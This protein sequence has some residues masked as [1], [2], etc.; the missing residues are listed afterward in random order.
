[1][2]ATDYALKLD[3]SKADRDLIQKIVERSDTLYAL[4]GLK[5]DRLTRSLDLTAC[6]CNG[7]PLDLAKLLAF[8]DANFGH[9]VLGIRRHIDRHT[10]KLGDCFLPRCAKPVPEKRYPGQDRD[11]ARRERAEER[12]IMRAENGHPDAGYP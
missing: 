3:T 4:V 10:G 2:A 5:D 12:R 1:M 11:E 8:D 9:D 6:H 7:T